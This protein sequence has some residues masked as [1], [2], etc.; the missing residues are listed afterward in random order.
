MSEPVSEMD[1]PHEWKPFVRSDFTW[2]QAAGAQKA[3][4]HLQL[5]SPVISGRYHLAVYSSRKA[6]DCV[7]PTQLFFNCKVKPLS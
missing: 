6:N 1:N 5:A 7:F 4:K 2:E 3:R